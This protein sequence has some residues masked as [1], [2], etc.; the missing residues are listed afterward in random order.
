MGDKAYPDS[1]CQELTRWDGVNDAHVGAGLPRVHHEARRSAPVRT[2]VHLFVETL[3]GVAARRQRDLPA[4]I[5]GLSRVRLAAAV[6][7]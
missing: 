1:Y 7:D 5:G 6:G 2:I 3:H 4:A